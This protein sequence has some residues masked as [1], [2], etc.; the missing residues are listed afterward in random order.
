MTLSDPDF[1]MLKHGNEMFYALYECD[2][3]YKFLRPKDIVR[4]GNEDRESGSKHY[5]RITHAESL[6]L[7]DYLKKYPESKWMIERQI[8]EGLDMKKILNVYEFKKTYDFVV[9]REKTKI[10]KK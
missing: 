10:N 3:R 6:K 1:S 4:I 5:L 8:G 9:D 7:E 2:G